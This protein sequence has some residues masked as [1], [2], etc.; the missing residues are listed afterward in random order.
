MTPPQGDTA[1]LILCEELA[2][3]S[4]IELLVFDQLLWWLNAKK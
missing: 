3:E 4:G 2:N 1:L